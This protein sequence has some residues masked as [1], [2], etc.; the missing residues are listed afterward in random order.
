MNRS[1]W[2]EYFEAINGR[3]ATGEELAAA[4]ENGEIV[5][6]APSQP[7]AAQAT[8]TVV[9][10]EAA[11]VNQVPPVQ[12]EAAQQGQVPPAPQAA[13]LVSPERQEQM[14]QTSR[15]FWNWFVSALKAPTSVVQTT[16]ANG[17]IAFGLLTLFYTLTVFI[18]ARKTAG[19]GS[20]FINGLNSYYSDSSTPF[21][22][23]PVGF[24]AFM[25]ILVGA[26][27]S[28]FAII[29]AGFVAKRFVYSD[30]QFTLTKAFDWY[31]RLFS[32][33]IVMMAFTTLFVLIDVYSIAFILIVLS[34]LVFGLATTFALAHSRD[35]SS[36]DMFYKYILAVVVNGLVLFVFG[37]L[38][39]MIAGEYLVKLI[40][41]Y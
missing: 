23:N 11:Q 34:L 32:V 33:N 25:A 5:D 37:V 35:V 4:M 9:A 14:K 26:A 24:S 27:L 38:S 30:T 29:F 41:F 6:I 40:S 17:W 8:T 22:S 3:P 31:G 7:Q 1:D 18:I 28:L 10:P 2:L 13:P 39:A 21:M 19:V 16:P 36:L 12:P 15:N 20:N